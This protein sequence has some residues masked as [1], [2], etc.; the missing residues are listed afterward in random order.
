[1]ECMHARLDGWDLEDFQGDQDGEEMRAWLV[2]SVAR[3][4]AVD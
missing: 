2:T 3:A 1:M 4:V